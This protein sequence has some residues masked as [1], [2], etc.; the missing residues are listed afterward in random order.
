LNVSVEEKGMGLKL[1]EP[2]R[3]CLR[4]LHH[5]AGSVQGNLPGWAV[6]G[7]PAKP[8]ISE[9][10]GAASGDRT[11]RPYWPPAS[12]RIHIAT[13][14]NNATVAVDHCTLLHAAV[15][16][17]GSRDGRAISAANAVNC[18]VC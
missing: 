17:S 3:R 14:A 13:V 8:L 1:C 2:G 10:F 6:G 16:C 18:R 15:L 9:A 12:Y 5:C 7:A 4:H 11:F